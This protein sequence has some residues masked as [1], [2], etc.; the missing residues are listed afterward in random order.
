MIYLKALGYF[1]LFAVITLLALYI[2]AWI[3]V[4]DRLVRWCSHY[5][6]SLEECKE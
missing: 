6:N 1:L 2:I 4:V 3:P 5:P